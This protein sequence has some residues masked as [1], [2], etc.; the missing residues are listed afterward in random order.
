MTNR[1]LWRDLLEYISSMEK[2]R[3]RNNNASNPIS[4]VV[5]EAYYDEDVTEIFSATSLDWEGL[6]R[7]LGEEFF[8]PEGN[9]RIEEG[10]GFSNADSSVFEH[11]AWYDSYHYGRKNWG[12]HI[13]E[14]CWAG[15]ARRLQIEASK[16]NYTNSTNPS[17]GSD[18]TR[19]S[20]AVRGAFFMLFLHE[21]FHYQVDIAATM[22]EITT[23]RPNYYTNYS[24]NV[25]WPSYRGS[26][27]LEEALA[28][29]YMFGRFEYCR[30]NR[31]YLH[32]KLLLEGP[33]YRDFHLYKGQNFWQGRRRLMNQILRCVPAVPNE[34]PIE[35][36][37]EIL[38][39]DVDAKGNRVPI[40]LHP[41]RSGRRRIFIKDEKKGIQI[42]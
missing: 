35:Q 23:G 2:D 1:E 5:G 37:M 13:G 39:P 34:A 22:I 21:F 18:F 29:R 11:C 26:G 19:S 40:W 31:D 9:Q 33:G 6:G 16:A 28:N 41:S 12:I 20:E 25:Y 17:K 4:E 15:L 27:A 8:L 24:R 32:A 7:S 3:L 42:H 36:L 14:D 10:E 38:S 30:I